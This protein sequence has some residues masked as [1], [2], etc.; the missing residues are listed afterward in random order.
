[1]IKLTA[2]SLVLKEAAVERLNSKE[3]EHEPDWESLG[4]RGP[5]QEEE[6][7]FTDEDFEKIYSTCHVD[8]ESIEIIMG[9]PDEKEGSIIYTKSGLHVSVQ[10]S[11]EEVE[12]LR[13]LE[14]SFFYRLKCLVVSL[15]NRTFTDRNK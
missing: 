11:E 2:T 4:L 8:E 3:E 10:E 15:K 7:D 6:D 12:H 5:N 13:K 9:D 14:K 1:M